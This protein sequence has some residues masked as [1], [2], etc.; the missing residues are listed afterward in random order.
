MNPSKALGDD[1]LSALFYQRFWGT[2][3][4]EVIAVCL[5][6]LNNNASVECLNE[7]LIALIPKKY[8]PIRVED[9]RL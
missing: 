5:N 9:F 8:N 2:I 4:N 1:G 6:I 7:T 3:K